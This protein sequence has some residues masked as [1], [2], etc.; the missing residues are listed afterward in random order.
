MMSAM[1][2]ECPTKKGEEGFLAF[3]LAT[4]SS[5][6]FTLPANRVLHFSACCVVINDIV[7]VEVKVEVEVV[8]EFEFFEVEVKFK[9]VEQTIES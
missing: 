6:F 2:M 1:V 9:A 8:V 7:R 3:L 5:R 4:S